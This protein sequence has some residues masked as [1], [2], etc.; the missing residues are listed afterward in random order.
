MSNHQ[1]KW[2]GWTGAALPDHRDIK[3]DRR[4]DAK[5]AGVPILPSHVD[6]RGPKM[7]AVYNQSQLGSCTANGWAGLVQFVALKEGGVDAWMPSRLFIYHQELVLEGDCTGDNGA[8]VKTG[9]KVVSQFGWPNEASYPYLIDLGSLLATPP[10]AIFTAA[11]SNKA[12][13]YQSVA[14]NL[15]DM[16]TCLAAGYPFVFGFTVYQSFESDI[17]AQTG[18]VPMPGPKESVL[19]GHC[20][21]AVGYD[22]PS[23]RMIVRNSWGSDWGQ[24]GYFT[25]PYA[26]ITSASLAADLWTVRKVS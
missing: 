13:Q 12:L 8:S 2:Y 18:V 22:D 9:G 26:Y 4:K 19:G 20:V 3:Y 23:A 25:M 11:S 6:L 15:Q 5:K 10:P 1:I 24:A 14:Q 21:M 17:V 16:K 7:P